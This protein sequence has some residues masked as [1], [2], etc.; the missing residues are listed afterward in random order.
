MPPFCSMR[1]A[2]S[3]ELP[4]SI[5]RPLPFIPLILTS[6]TYTSEFEIRM[7]S[8]SRPG[9]IETREACMMN[10]LAQDSY[11]RRNDPGAVRLRAY[12]RYSAAQMERLVILTRGNRDRVARPSVLDRFGDSPESMRAHDQVFRLRTVPKRTI[13]PEAVCSRYGRKAPNNTAAVSTPARN[14]AHRGGSEDELGRGS[15]AELPHTPESR[16]GQRIHCL[17]RRPGWPLRSKRQL[18]TPDLRHVV[19]S[20]QRIFS[21]G[22]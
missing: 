19:R 17:C 15:V 11:F 9:D 4:P 1:Q 7:P 12:D 5:S 13:M 18:R 2:S 3:E 16:P 6:S 21:A 8:F 20:R 14:Q 10:V 22:T